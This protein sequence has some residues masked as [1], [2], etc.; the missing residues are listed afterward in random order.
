MVT[1][2]NLSRPPF[3]V[4]T[5]DYGI[6]Q[7]RRLVSGDLRKIELELKENPEPIPFCRKVIARQI[8]RPTS[9]PEP[10]ETISEASLVALARE[11][12]KEELGVDIGSDSLADV[13]HDLLAAL[14]NYRDKLSETARMGLAN[15]PKSMPAIAAFAQNQE[16]LAKSIGALNASSSLFK[17]NDSVQR[18]NAAIEPAISAIRNA[19]KLAQPIRDAMEAGR[20]ARTAVE[21][22]KRMAAIAN[23]SLIATIANI[24]KNF[25]QISEVGNALRT[26][27]E[28]FRGAQWARFAATGLFA[29]LPDLTELKRHWKAV[30]RGQ[31][32]IAKAGFKVSF[33]LIDVTFAASLSQDDQRRQSISVNRQFFEMTRQNDFW[34]VLE[35][36]LSA[37]PE[38]VRRL[39]IIK[40]AH[41]AHVARKYWVAIPT[42][43]AQLEGLFTDGLLLEKA[44]QKVGRDRLINSTTRKN[45]TGLG[46]KVTFVMPEGFDLIKEFLVVQVVNTGDDK[47]FIKTRN[48][49]L[50]GGNTSY[51]KPKFSAQLLF[52]ILVIAT[53]LEGL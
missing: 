47:S 34:E 51:R 20:L 13:S 30:E 42:L 18:A 37:T 32:A 48:D 3:S 24:Q 27:T 12:S 23:P 2:R 22:I 46:Q 52:A 26:V 49:I 11:W 25:T 1:A 7:I 5:P 8:E 28:E 4:E 16:R 21:A 33:G 36:R 40:E 38:G 9:I 14:T 53:E 39:P 29:Q 43:I 35:E 41:E 50:H 31:D 6:V 45:I 10:L 15:I 44:I 19:E 17:A